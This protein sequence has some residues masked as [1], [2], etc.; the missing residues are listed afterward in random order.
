MANVPSP[1]DIQAVKYGLV[2]LVF[3]TASAAYTAYRL[4]RGLYKGI[5]LVGRKLFVTDEAVAEHIAKKH[6]G[7]IV[8]VKNKEMSHM[9]AGH[10]CQCQRCQQKKR[11]ERRAYAMAQRT[12]P[13][14]DDPEF[15]AIVQVLPMNV[16]RF[17]EMAHSR[18]LRCEYY[19]DSRFVVMG[20]RDV[21]IDFLAEA[22]RALLGEELKPTEDLKLAHALSQMLD[23]PSVVGRRRNAIAMAHQDMTSLHPVSEKSKAKYRELLR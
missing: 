22:R 12:L 15:S 10:R 1:Q 20:P 6:E 19:S 8:D 3:A 9:P 17:L 13:R 5:K 7:D 4:A 11:L 14:D 2:V 16:A 21:V 23:D 18:D